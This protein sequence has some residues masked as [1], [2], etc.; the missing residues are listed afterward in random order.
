MKAASN[1]ACGNRQLDDDWLK[2]MDMTEGT[3]QSQ[4]LSLGRK[5]HTP[6]DIW[7]RHAFV[8]ELR[9]ALSSLL[10]WLGVRLLRR[11]RTWRLLT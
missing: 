7:V 5:D 10:A 9:D 8:Y 3:N 6:H 4:I 11:R 2:L 1:Q